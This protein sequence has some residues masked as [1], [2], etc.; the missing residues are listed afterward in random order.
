MTKNFDEYFTT[1]CEAITVKN[2]ESQIH[3][4]Q[5][6]IKSLYRKT[7]PSQYESSP[8]EYEHVKILL[9][10]TVAEYIDFINVNKDEIDNYPDVADNI[11][12]FGIFLRDINN[13][14]SSRF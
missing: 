7:D 8:R 1:I 5:R 13:Y 6:K 3:H 12:D 10:R 14:R 2:V 9:D 4:F 11:R